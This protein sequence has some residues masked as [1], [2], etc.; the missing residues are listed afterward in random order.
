MFCC[1]AFST[2]KPFRKPFYTNKPYVY[3]LVVLF[4]FNAA[5][6]WLPP[7]NPVS[8]FFGVVPFTYDDGSEAYIYKGWLSLAIAVNSALTIVAEIIIV[9]NV[10]T[11]AD[12]R[13]LNKKTMKFDQH[14]DDLK[15]ISI[16]QDDTKLNQVG[17]L[18]R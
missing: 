17:D 16:L 4:L 14:M 9:N 12:K 10:T 18:C 8:E 3:S 7:T 13:R 1:I 15:K 5:L 6:I 2:S 11:V